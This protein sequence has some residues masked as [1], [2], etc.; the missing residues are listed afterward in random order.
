M[1]A[2]ETFML[3]WTYP[4]SHG[5]SVLHTHN[6]ERV[7]VKLLYI[8]LCVPYIQWNLSILNT[9]G[10]QMKCSIYGGVRPR[11]LPQNNYNILF[12]WY[13]TAFGL[14]FSSP[15]FA[16]SDFRFRIPLPAPTEIPN[17]VAKFLW[18]SYWWV[19]ISAVSSFCVSKTFF[20]KH[21][22]VVYA[23]P[24]IQTDSKSLKC[25]PLKP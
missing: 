18:W 14:K 17:S 24:H 2:V 16:N 11:G 3:Q 12:Y 19:S 6:E 10:T 9:F 21:K 20:H 25:A 5:T 13:Y 8:C 7:Y 4:M 1:C 22:C 15:R 23:G